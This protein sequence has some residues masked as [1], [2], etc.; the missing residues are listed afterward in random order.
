MNVEVGDWLGPGSVVATLIDSARVEIGIQ[1]PAAVYDRAKVGAA[2]Q[3][4]SESMPDVRWRGRVARIAPFVDERTRTFAAYVEVDNAEQDQP[5]VPGTFVRAEVA[6]PRH[7]RVLA[8]PRGAIRDDAV[9]VAQDGKA[10]LRSIVPGRF[11]A[12]RVIVTGEIAAGDVLILS[13]LSQ[14][15]GGSPIR[16]EA[17]DSSAAAAP[18][19]PIGGDRSAAP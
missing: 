11:V 9:L 19:S 8:V 13:H 15:R 18:S 7:D 16:L 14:L 10:Q 4:W 3:V 2:C 12:D 6:G 1:L 5:C 17:A